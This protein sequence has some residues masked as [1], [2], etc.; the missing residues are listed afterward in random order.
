MGV[1]LQMGL[2]GTY[3]GVVDIRTELDETCTD[4]VQVAASM[5]VDCMPLEAGGHC[6]CLLV[7][8]CLHW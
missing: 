7:A 5:V 3:M 2:D 4:L 8:E 1:G 6:S